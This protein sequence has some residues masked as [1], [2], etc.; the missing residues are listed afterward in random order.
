MNNSK[1]STKSSLPRAMTF[2]TLT[3][4]L[5]TVSRQWRVTVGKRT[6]SV[7]NVIARGSEDLVEH[8]ELFIAK[9]ILQ[10]IMR[11]AKMPVEDTDDFRK[12][13]AVKSCPRLLH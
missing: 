11:F 12:I 5:P 9:K 4:R 7:V 1:C 8:F 13:R 3:V 2:T 6:V 10:R